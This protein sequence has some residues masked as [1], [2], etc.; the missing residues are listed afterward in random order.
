MRKFLVLG[1]AMVAL[2][3]LVTIAQGGDDSDG[4]HIWFFGDCEVNPDTSDGNSA[5]GLFLGSGCRGIGIFSGD[6]DN[7]SIADRVAYEAMDEFGG[8]WYVEYLKAINLIG[9]GTTIGE[10][11]GCDYEEETSLTPS[12]Y[13]MGGLWIAL[14]SVE[15]CN[16][17]YY[18]NP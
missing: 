10:G 8:Y 9:G 5:S 2:F 1:A 18:Y 3:S 12:V 4:A 11:Y 17:Y 15:P 14:F 7:Y 16:G 6:W 13:N